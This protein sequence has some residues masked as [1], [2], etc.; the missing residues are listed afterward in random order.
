MATFRLTTASC[1]L[2]LSIFCLTLQKN[3]TDQTPGQFPPA[4]PEIQPEFQ[5]H[6]NNS[7]ILS[8]SNVINV[9]V[10]ENICTYS[11]VSGNQFQGHRGRQ[12]DSNC[13]ENIGISLL[14]PGN[15][16]V[17]YTKWLQKYRNGW[18]T[19]RNKSY[20]LMV[21]LSPTNSPAIKNQSYSNQYVPKM[22]VWDNYNDICSTTLGNSHTVV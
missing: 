6:G 18:N 22:T 3:P 20:G 7:R 11:T 1:L 10:E 13:G 17:F 19:W 4:E 16:V 15:A 9:G 5:K 21:G 14:S 2:F 8:N 12:L